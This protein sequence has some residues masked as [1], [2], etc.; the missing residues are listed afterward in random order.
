M[1]S[2]IASLLVVL[3]LL[4]PVGRGEAL[5]AKKSWWIG[6]YAESCGFSEATRLPEAE[7]LATGVFC[8]PFSIR[9][10]NPALFCGIL[11]PIAPFQGEGVRFQ[12]GGELTLIDLP[13]EALQDFF[14]N[15]ICLSPALGAECLLKP[16]LSSALF[17][18]IISP[19][20]FRAG[21]GVFTLCSLH[22]FLE[23]GPRFG[24]WGF[25]LFKAALYLL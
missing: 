18:V 7:Y 8:E 20:R 25:M 10:F 12:L 14:Y 13:A 9:V 19:L 21:D 24:G 4:V 3:L 16:D 23:P 6:L 1:Q 5:G 2:R 15:T 11:L 22:L 17:D